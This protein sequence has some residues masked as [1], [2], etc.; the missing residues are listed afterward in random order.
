MFNRKLNGIFL[1]ANAVVWQIVYVGSR[2]RLR[3]FTCRTNIRIKVFVLAT[4]LISV[5]TLGTVNC[6]AIKAALANPV[7][8]LRYE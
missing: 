5:I 7:G 1:V 4:I 2:N 8:S 6:L 3:D